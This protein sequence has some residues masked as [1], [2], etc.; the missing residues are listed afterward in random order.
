MKY[1]RKLTIY[2]KYPVSILAIPRK[3]IFVFLRTIITNIK[4]IPIKINKKYRKQC[5]RNS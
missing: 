5:C 2:E 1:S 4:Q 3:A